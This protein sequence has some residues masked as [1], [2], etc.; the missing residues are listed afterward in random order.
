MP[1][2][3]DFLE[4]FTIIQPENHTDLNYKS[5]I[6]SCQLDHLTRHYDS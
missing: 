3:E 4:A 5:I 6:Y 2:N 1:T